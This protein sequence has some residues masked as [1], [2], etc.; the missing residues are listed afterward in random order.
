[1]TAPDLKDRTLLQLVALL[2]FNAESPEWIDTDRDL[3]K[4]RAVWG[5]EGADLDAEL[6]RIHAE[7]LAWQA[8]SLRQE[9]EHIAALAKVA[10][11]SVTVVNDPDGTYGKA[12]A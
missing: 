8:N 1:M 3:G 10:I 9:R 12:A 4:L 6:A 7:V 11:Q 2:R 5:A